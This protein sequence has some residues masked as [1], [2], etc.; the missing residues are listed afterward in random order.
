MAEVLRLHALGW[1]VRAIAKHA[2]L[3]RMTVH[4]IID[5]DRPVIPEVDQP[6]EPVPE[7]PALGAMADEKAIRR[8]HGGLEPWDTEDGLAP[9]G[10]PSGVRAYKA[11]PLYGTRYWTADD[12]LAGRCGWD[13]LNKLH[14]Y[15]L[16][17]RCLQAEGEEEKNF[18]PRPAS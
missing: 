10:G 9:D 6:P 5:A 14:Q 7:H 17:W 11:D 2:G 3:S 12:H 16:R 1:S 4:R 18:G 13:D 8:Q 15:R